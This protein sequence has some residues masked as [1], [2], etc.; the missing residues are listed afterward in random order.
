MDDMITC[1]ENVDM[2]GLTELSE[3]YLGEL[4]QSG[5]CQKE[6]LSGKTLLL[7]S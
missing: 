4:N 5:S 3:K 2:S 1:F 7:T 6:I